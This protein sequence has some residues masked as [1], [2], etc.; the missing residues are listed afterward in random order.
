MDSTQTSW[1]SV[2]DRLFEQTS[3]NE[4]RVEPGYGPSYERYYRYFYNI[5]LGKKKET[6]RKWLFQDVA[7]YIVS[8]HQGFS[9]QQIDM[10]C[11]ALLY[12]MR[13]SGVAKEEFSSAVG[14]GCVVCA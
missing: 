12:P 5:S 9:S 1:K 8:N 14:F 6:L 7:Q 10:L 4:H 2:I 3:A 13:V 11:D